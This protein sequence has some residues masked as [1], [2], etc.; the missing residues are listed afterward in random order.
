MTNTTRAVLSCHRLC[1]SY[2][3]DQLKL[4]VLSNIE[5]KVHSGERVAIVGRSGAGKSTLLTLLGG[6]DSPDSGSV[7]ILDKPLHELKESELTQAR[8]RHLGFVYQFHHLLG[9]FSA[10]EN[11]ALPL[12]VAG[13]RPQRAQRSASDILE[14]VGLASRQEHYPAELSGGERQRV[15][16]A[17]ALVAKPDC[18]LLDEPTG[19]LDSQTASEVQD[20][21]F[22]LSS[23]LG[24]AFV[25]VTHD[26]RL[27]S[28]MEKV[29][30]LDNGKLSLRPTDENSYAQ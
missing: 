18:V 1:K 20:L 24:T 23:K 14:R 19:N 27:A 15:A 10:L 11:V 3:R 29:Y 17:R 5:L 28:M 7:Q 12:M 25:T 4:N 21:M 30:I 2:G 13:L 26:N 9:E 16:I 8:N 22:D 6:L